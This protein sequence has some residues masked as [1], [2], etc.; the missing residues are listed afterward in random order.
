MIKLVKLAIRNVLRNKRRSLITMLIILISFLVLNIYRGYIASAEKYWGETLIR[1]DYGHLQI[2]NKDYA[3]DDP[4]S[5]DHTISKQLYE[6]IL[7]ITENYQEIRFVTPRLEIMGL[8]GGEEESKTFLAS[9]RDPEEDDEMYILDQVKEGEFISMENPYDI[10]IGKKLAEKLNV[11][12]NGNL[13]LIAQ[14][15][16][17]SLEAIEVTVSGFS[18]SG[19]TELDNMRI[20]TSL[21]ATQNLVLT[22]SFHYIIVLL[23]ST[24][25][26][27]KMQKILTEEFKNQGLNLKIFNFYERA[28]FFTDIIDM[29]KRSFD[30]S[31]AVLAIIIIF[32]LLNT[33]YMSIT[34]RTKEFA[35]MKTIGI[36]RRTIFSSIL[37]EGVLIALIAVIIG[38]FLSYLS[39]IMINNAA[40]TLDPPPGSDQRIPFMVL[41]KF[42]YLSSTGIIFIL[43]AG[44]ASIFP[45]IH[46]IK[47][48]IVKAL[49]SQ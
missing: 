31:L 48:K 27:F 11:E 7:N 49:V 19:Y 32:S 2:F 46:V 41:F 21:E 47:Q 30:I 42:D 40:I 13:L 28:R 1:Q 39:F 44:F 10:V 38:S 5:F 23:K 34:D 20:F 8:I 45:A 37:L 24:G 18:E 3:L 35:T 17:G 12:L 14:S 25:E 43:I 36:A 9:A 6:K 26:M 22:D 16:Y 29:Q 33:I 15:S 4:T